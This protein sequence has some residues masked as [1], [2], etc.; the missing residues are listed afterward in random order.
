MGC[1]ES[2]VR[3]MRL[4]AEMTRDRDLWTSAI[5]GNHPNCASMEK[6]TLRR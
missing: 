3:K 4:K 2:N 5:H 6:W 1:V